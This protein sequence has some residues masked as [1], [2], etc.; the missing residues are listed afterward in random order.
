[1]K[2]SAGL[3]NSLYCRWIGCA[4]QLACKFIVG[5]WGGHGLVSQ[6]KRRRSDPYDRPSFFV[7]LVPSDWAQAFSIPISPLQ[8]RVT[9]PV[10]IHGTDGVGSDRAAHVSAARGR[11]AGHAVYARGRQGTRRG[12]VGEEVEEAVWRSPGTHDVRAR[13]LRRPRAA[14]NCATRCLRSARVSLGYRS[15]LCAGGG[16]GACGRVARRN[17]ARP[18]SE[19]CNLPADAFGVARTEGL[20]Y[21]DAGYLLRPVADATGRLPA[22]VDGVHR[23]RPQPER[24]PRVFSCAG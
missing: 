24:Q 17:A 14:G 10:E 8:L 1:M 22:R 13:G 7:S 15:Q 20:R 11:F 18:R 9:E 4:L 3:R 12:A 16:A 23:L 21:M 6:R 2:V 5:F 19:R